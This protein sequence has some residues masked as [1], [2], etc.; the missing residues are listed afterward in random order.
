M[1][2]GKKKESA[3][4][5]EEKLAQALVPVEEQP[6]QIPG[7]WCWTTVGN[8]CSFVGGGTPDKSN[9]EYWG[10][11]IPWASVK[12][13]KDSKLYD[14][15]DRITQ[16]G[17][18]HSASN[19]CQK[20]EL[21]LVTRIEPGKAIVS[22]IVTAINQDLKVIKS[23]LDASF[24]FYYFQTFQHKFE[25]KASGSTVKGIT[26]PNVQG[27]VF[28][29]PP[30]AEQQRIVGRIEYLFAKLDEAKEKA[31]SVLDSFETRKAAILHKA[32]TG[33]LTAKW[34]TEHS[35]TLE[36]WHDTTVGNL[37]EVFSGK[38]FKE[39]EY[40]LSGIKLLRISN[41]TYDELVWEDT[42]Y[43]P[44]EYLDTVPELVLKSGDIVMALNRP[45]TNG[46]L[47]V[48]IVDDIERYILY[49]R[50][51]CLRKRNPENSTQYL[52]YAL[53]SQS[54]LHQ[55]ES[56]LQGSDQPYINLP[57]LKSLTIALCSEPE[58][59]E[60][61]RILDSLL[62]KEQQAKEAAEAVLEKID[63]LKKSILARAFR[64]ELGTNDPNE[65][66]AQ[67]LLKTVL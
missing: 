19:L 9:P 28:P 48:S 55:V 8:V 42:K 17:L 46:K 66:S 13:V 25:E 20:G 14:T 53:L 43:L 54:F 58:Q 27:T 10:G 65:E 16:V 22:E 5:P 38:G 11:D 18:E 62:A 67:E 40:S 7:N 49:Q 59:K 45:I 1:A 47:K 51:G 41:V 24:L 34:R 3:L 30:L 4:T 61:V 23:H 56:H 63:L 29:L 52:Q 39:K 12:D 60:V 15:V 44:V 21:I 37:F 2:R 64:G 32:F 26:I 57:P 6:Y 35:V 50:V 31:Q 33:E 36:G